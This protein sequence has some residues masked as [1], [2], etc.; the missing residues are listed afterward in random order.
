MQFV[1][2]AAA[3]SAASRA[4]KDGALLLLN[5][6]LHWCRNIVVGRQCST[7]SCQLDHSMSEG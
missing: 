2:S 1:G 6:C 4:S 5:S 7:V 3:A